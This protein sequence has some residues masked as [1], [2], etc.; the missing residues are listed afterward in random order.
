M[1]CDR[2]TLSEMTRRTNEHAHNYGLIRIQP[3]SPSVDDKKVAQIA[4]ALGRSRFTRS[5]LDVAAPPNRKRG[6]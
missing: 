2:C 4:E 3:I 1:P 5:V 6:D